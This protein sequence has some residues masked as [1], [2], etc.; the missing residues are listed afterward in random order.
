MFM[1]NKEKGKTFTVSMHHEG[2]VISCTDL[3]NL[4]KLPVI[5]PP[6]WRDRYVCLWMDS[7]WDETGNGELSVASSEGVEQRGLGL[8]IQR[9]PSKEQ[10][11]FKP[12]LDYKKNIFYVYILQ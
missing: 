5:S 2:D 1:S 12:K 6:F 10:T 4:W 3:Y 8:L 9:W 11:Q 7:V